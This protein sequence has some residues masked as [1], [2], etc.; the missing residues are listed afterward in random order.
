M[1]D[2]G[3]EARLCVVLV[4]Y[5]I[6]LVRRLCRLLLDPSSDPE[7]VQDISFSHK[8][9]YRSVFSK[10]NICVKGSMT[11]YLLSR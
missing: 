10:I 5:C 3:A 9:I 2:E 4:G 8:Y 7:P 11:D 6:V 1:L